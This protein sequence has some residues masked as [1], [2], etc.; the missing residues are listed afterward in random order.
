V[1]R[2]R[3]LSV[4]LSSL[5][6][7]T[8]HASRRCS[9]LSNTNNNNCLSA[10]YSNNVSPGRRVE[11]VTQSQCRY[12]GL[13][14]QLTVPKLGQ[15]SQPHPIRE[16]PTHVG[17]QPQRQ[18]RLPHPADTCQ[19]Q[20]LSITQEPPGLRQLPSTTDETRAIDG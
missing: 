2:I 19:R 16:R 11:I 7:R 17:R 8:A 4:W 5:V 3:K 14:H 18:P 9:Q 13:R 15:I 6:A 20:Q 12:H 10:R 1:A